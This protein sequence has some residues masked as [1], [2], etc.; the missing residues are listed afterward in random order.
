MRLARRQVGQPQNT[1]T[2][3]I[4]PQPMAENGYA[5]ANPENGQP[6]AKGTP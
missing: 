1:R 5:V 6:Q 3:I 4:I 2:G